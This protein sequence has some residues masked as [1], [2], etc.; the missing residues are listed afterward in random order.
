MISSLFTCGLFSVDFHSLPVDLP[1]LPADFRLFTVIFD[2]FHS[3]PA[4][5][6][7][8]Y[9][10]F[11]A[12]SISFR[13]SFRH[14]R[15]T[16]LV[17]K[18]RRAIRRYPVAAIKRRVV[19]KYLRLKGPSNVMAIKRCK[20]LLNRITNYRYDYTYFFA[21]SICFIQNDLVGPYFARDTT[22][23]KLILILIFEF[24]EYIKKSKF[25]RTLAFKTRLLEYI[26]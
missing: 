18:K 22:F 19:Q 26:K 10:H 1:Y 21:I 2:H 23:Q 11:R 3:I 4:D 17:L 12:I 5:F 24:N 9:C 14:F 13:F 16:P 7:L 25:P 8:I 6:R 15:G 20:I